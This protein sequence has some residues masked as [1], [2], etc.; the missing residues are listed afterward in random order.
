VIDVQINDFVLSLFPE[1]FVARHRAEGMSIM[2]DP[3]LASEDEL[4]AL[5]LRLP[6]SGRVHAMFVIGSASR[7]LHYP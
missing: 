4:R 3:L 7:Q 2:S 5:R 1:D 6:H